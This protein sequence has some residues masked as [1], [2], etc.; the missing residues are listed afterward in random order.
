LL[1]F[2]IDIA[3]DAPDVLFDIEVSGNKLAFSASKLSNFLS[4]CV[5]ADFSLE[6]FSATLQLLDET[7]TLSQQTVAVSVGD[8]SDSKPVLTV[9]NTDQK[10]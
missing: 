6:S 1:P 10:R 5:A 2:E 4:F 9:T 7:F 3:F 8:P